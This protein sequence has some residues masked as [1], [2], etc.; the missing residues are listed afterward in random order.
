MSNGERYTLLQHKMQAGVRFDQA[1][2]PQLL[3]EQTLPAHVARHLKMERVG[4]N[5][6]RIEIGALTKLLIAKGVFTDDEWWAEAC[7]MM[8]AEIDRY[9]R[10]LTERLG[11]PVSLDTPYI[12]PV[13]GTK[14]V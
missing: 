6:A 4:I 9:E 2:D 7:A 10:L 14:R 1:T 5:S 3:A 12:D 8:Q 13:A 11:Q